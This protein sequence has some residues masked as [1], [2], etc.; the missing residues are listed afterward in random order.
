[1]TDFNKRI[2][3]AL[4]S[5]VLGKIEGVK[6]YEMTPPN[7]MKVRPNRAMRRAKRHQVY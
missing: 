1:M 6:I 5:G 3:Y 4:K 2:R 7:M